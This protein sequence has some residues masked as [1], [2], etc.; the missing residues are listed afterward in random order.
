MG[1]LDKV[2]ELVKAF[3]RWLT[4][5]VVIEQEQLAFI[6]RWGTHHRELQP[7]LR[8]KWPIA[9]VVE[10]EDSRDYPYVLDPQSLVTKDNVDVVLKLGL[11]V[12]VIDPRKYYAGVYDGRANIQD[13]ASGALGDYVREATYEEV[14]GKK[15]LQQV[16]RTVRV[17]ANKWGME[18]SDVRFIDCVKAPSFRLWN[19]QTASAGQD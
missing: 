7:G 12:R 2:I 14:R 17:S 18:V 1:F 16:S 8:W 15:V 6:R 9:E 11:T 4:I 5:C 10:L 3:W 19:T 13:I